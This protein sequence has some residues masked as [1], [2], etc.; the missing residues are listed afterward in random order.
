MM[1]L[2]EALENKKKKSDADDAITGSD[3]DSR[4]EALLKYIES[5]KK[6]T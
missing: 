6:K 4:G 1:K 3:E 2:V 5:L